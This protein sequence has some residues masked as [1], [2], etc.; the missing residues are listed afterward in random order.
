MTSL[1]SIARTWLTLACLVLVQLSPGQEAPDSPKKRNST[2]F[3]SLYNLPIEKVKI[4]VDLDSLLEGRM[5]NDEH[6]AEMHVYTDK[7]ITMML[8]LNISV[9]SRSRRRLC[10]FP[11]LKFDFVK[12]DL[13]DMG[14]R[15]QDD[16]KIVTHCLD[17]P[18]GEQVLVKEFLIY[19]LYQIITPMSLRAKL[20]D[21]TYINSVSKE[22]FEK[23]AIILESD[24]EFAKRQDGKLCNCMGTSKD[25]IDPFLFEQLAM[26]QFMIGNADMAYLVERNVK[27]VRQAP[28]KPMIPL[29]Y[30]FDFAAL[31][32]APYVYP[33]VLDNRSLPRS[34]LGF[35]DYAHVL[36]EVIQKFVQKKE[37][38]FSYIEAFEYISNFERRLCLQYVKKF[39][40]Q[41]EK[42][43]VQLPYAKGH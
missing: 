29:A 1:F 36:P 38:I 32:N 42:K 40:R 27:F 3:D 10:D 31:V 41:I 15:K 9:R 14:L 28:D 26:F 5:T 13:K 39:Y 35:R 34:Y 22:E 8:P 20:V 12:G 17:G 37:E 18:Q 6:A 2:L 21:M 23:K 25:S 11:P 43:K 4:V 24:K 16:Y 30:D 7:G 33:R 19:Q